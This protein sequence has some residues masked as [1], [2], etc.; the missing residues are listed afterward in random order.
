MVCWR[1]GGRGPQ[2]FASRK[3][4]DRASAPDWSQRAET[5]TS[6]ARAISFQ[7]P[8]R[9]GSSERLACGVR[10]GAHVDG[11][12]TDPAVGGGRRRVF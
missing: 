6:Q 1:L 12:R 10:R 2:A 11:R 4:L 3:D 5:R 7:S 8:R 9:K